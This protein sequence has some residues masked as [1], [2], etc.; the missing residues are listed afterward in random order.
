MR[1]EPRL[2]YGPKAVRKLTNAISKA[3]NL[4]VT[5]TLAFTTTTTTT[6]ATSTANSYYL[7]SRRD[8]FADCFS[9]F[10]RTLILDGA[11]LQN[12]CSLGLES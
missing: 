4:T 7:A 6:T 5:I 9:M 8:C 1:I 12:L 10:L 2:E 11:A 3:F